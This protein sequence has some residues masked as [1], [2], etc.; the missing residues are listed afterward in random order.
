MPGNGSWRVHSET[1]VRWNKY[2]IPY[3]MDRIKAIGNAI[4]PQVAY[5][6]LKLIYEVE[7]KHGKKS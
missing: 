7:T 1:D 6:I 2:G 4:V 5:P 3:G